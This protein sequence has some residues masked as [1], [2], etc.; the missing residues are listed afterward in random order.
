MDIDSILPLKQT[1]RD[2]AD[3]Y[4]LEVQVNSNDEGVKEKTDALRKQLEGM[5]MKPQSPE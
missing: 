1:L 4:N 3:D 5:M 2:L